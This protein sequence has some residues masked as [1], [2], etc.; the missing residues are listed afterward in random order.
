MARH[1]RAMLEARTHAERDREHAP[2]EAIELVKQLARA[3]FDE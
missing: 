1:G 2:A 3:K